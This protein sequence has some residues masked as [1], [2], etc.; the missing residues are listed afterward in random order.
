MSKAEN[1]ERTKEG[2][3]KQAKEKRQESFD[4]NS[5]LTYNVHELNESIIKMSSYQ[6]RFFLLE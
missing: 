3:K 1:D 2:Y 5:R 6:F 4:M